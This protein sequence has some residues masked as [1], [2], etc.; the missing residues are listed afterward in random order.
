MAGREWGRRDEGFDAGCV[1]PAKRGPGQRQPS[2]GWG[3]E[4]ADRS[5]LLGATAG[6][7]ERLMGDKADDRGPLHAEGAAAAG[8]TRRRSASRWKGARLFARLQNARWLST[9][10]ERKIADFLTWF[11]LAACLIFA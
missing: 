5:G 3:R 9:P 4:G 2:P 1:S 7:P 11:R 10:G 8:R 6:K